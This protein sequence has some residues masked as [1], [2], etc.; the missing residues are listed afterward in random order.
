MTD[1][2]RN[3]PLINHLLLILMA[4]MLVYLV[5]SFARQVSI[6]YQRSEE[7]HRIEEEI[8]VAKE[9]YVRLQEHLSYVKST[10]ALE[11]WGRRHGWTKPNEVLVV[12]VGGRTE[13]SSAVPD[14]LE[15]S[16]EWDSSRDAWWDLFFGTR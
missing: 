14:A 5:V 11:I 2:V 15:E 16:K 4:I 13:S 7:L 6:S 12:P 9:E 1:K 8:G 3:T 10:E